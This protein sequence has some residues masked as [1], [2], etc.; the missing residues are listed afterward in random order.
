LK[1]RINILKKKIVGNGLD[2][3]LVLN[4]VNMFYLVG[5]RGGL[6]LLIPKDGKS[7]LY[8]SKMN[9]EAA[10]DS[11]KTCIIQLVDYGED[12][13]KVLCDQLIDLGLRK[14][15]FDVM[16]AQTYMK[17]VKL[18]EKLNFYP[19]REILWSMRQIKDSKELYFI[20][21]AAEITSKGMRRALE[22]VDINK[23]EKDVVA[24]IEYELRRNGADSIAFE[25]IV[26]SGPNSAYPHGGSGNR[27]LQRGDLIIIDLGAKSNGY[28]SDMTRT[29][30]LGKPSTKQL[31]IF[32]IVKE[33]QQRAL[34]ALNEEVT[35]KNIDAIARDFI[36]KKGLG[37]KFV[38]GLGH[39]VGLEV[40]E[41]PTLSP[42]SK[43]QLKN[44]NVVTVEP[45]I[46]IPGFGGVRIEDTVAITYGEAEVLTYA[47]Y[48]LEKPK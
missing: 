31:K 38:H 3:Y 37:E 16:D 30:V 34:E 28:C 47:P 5:F 1:R 40:H 9:Y 32:E 6:R 27:K 39:G 41:P 14:I 24:E 36:V 48:A 7:I 23:T 46:Y 12:I 2:G 35:A 13:D 44:G 20:K 4:E 45:G 10:K 21:K 43:D 11:V 18:Q 8:V 19:K 25:T 22:I 17:N 29:I 15:G 33:A 26:A 42:V